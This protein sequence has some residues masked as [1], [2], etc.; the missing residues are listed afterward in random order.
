[1]L[2][3]GL[4]FKKEKESAGYKLTEARLSQAKKMTKDMLINA[5]FC[6]CGFITHI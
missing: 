3:T 4:S 2:A 6:V 1:V 5:I